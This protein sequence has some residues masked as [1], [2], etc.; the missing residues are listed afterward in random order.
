MTLSIGLIMVVVFGVGINFVERILTAVMKGKPDE[1][2]VSTVKIIC[3]IGTIAGAV[4]VF[5]SEFT[6]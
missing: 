2:K 5:V 4:M 3:L 1:R 6:R